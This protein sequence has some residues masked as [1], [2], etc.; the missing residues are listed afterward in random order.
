MC[1]AIHVQEE[2]LP[3]INRPY[4]IRGTESSFVSSRSDYHNW[5]AQGLEQ[6]EL[7]SGDQLDGLQGWMGSNRKKHDSR[8]SH[9]TDEMEE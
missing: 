8:G 6:P 9:L 3:V 7:L 2:H 4:Q 1:L 5:T